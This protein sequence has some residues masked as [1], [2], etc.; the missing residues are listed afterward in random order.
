[1]EF[2]KILLASFE[3]AQAEHYQRI[4][5]GQRE[6]WMLD[7]RYEQAQRSVCEYVVRVN[8]WLT[9]LEN[10][11][12]KFDVLV[13][14]YIEARDHHAEIRRADNYQHYLY[15]LDLEQTR[16]YLAKATLMSLPYLK[17]D[18]PSGVVDLDLQ[19]DTMLAKTVLDFGHPCTFACDAKCEKAWGHQHRPQVYR[20]Q[21]D[22]WIAS[23]EPDEDATIPDV[24]DYAYL[25]DNELGKAPFDPGTYEG[26]EGKPTIPLERMNKWCFRE[27][28]RSETF[29]IG[30]P[31]VLHDWNKRSYNFSPHT[32]D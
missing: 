11:K 15:D 22:Q 8:Q 17:L 26:G 19:T 25:A 24:D 3:R 21:N 14:A 28:E 6:E 7:T 13:N 20:T 5:S 32:R 1:M 18:L 2:L 29:E 12:E 23:D 27:C 31:I 10:V 9:I 30:E 4:E 16:L